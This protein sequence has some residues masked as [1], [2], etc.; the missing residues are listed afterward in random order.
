VPTEARGERGGR[1][2]SGIKLCTNFDSAQRGERGGGEQPK[3]TWSFEL[4]KHRKSELRR[5]YSPKEYSGGAPNPPPNMSK[6]PKRGVIDEKAE[7]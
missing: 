7:Q 5:E 1:T 3:N 4:G 6:D 2:E